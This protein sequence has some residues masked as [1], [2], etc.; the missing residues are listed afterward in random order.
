MF[1]KDTLNKA[2]KQFEK[3]KKEYEALGK[4]AETHTLKLY[5]NRKVA[6]KTISRFRTF[7]SKISNLPD[8]LLMKLN[9]SSNIDGFYNAMEFEENNTGNHNIGKVMVAGVVTGSAVATMGAP[10]AMAVA[11]T[12]GTASTGTAI[13]T[14]SG[15]AATNAAIAWLG[16]G[17]LATGGGGISAGSAFLALAGPVGWSVAAVAVAGG[18]ILACF[19]NKKAAEEI[20]KQCIAI[21]SNIKLLTP[22][23]ERL[24]SINKE[25]A[26]WNLKTNILN[27]VNSYPRDYQ[28]FSCEQKRE[29]ND[30][31]DKLNRMVV[32]INE[33]IY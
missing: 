10:A 5:E 14:L 7:L 27:I 19:K 32:L 29:F 33:R 30:L 2:K 16:G 3:K 13:S 22:K 1:Y 21:D 25:I 28:M 23:L 20:K 24:I 4:R 8:S 12:F 9:S 11:T 18:G 15:A 26:E 17:A 31:L 6:A